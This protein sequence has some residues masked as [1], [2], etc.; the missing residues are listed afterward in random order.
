MS[1][2]LS[3]SNL[4]TSLL[5]DFLL[6]SVHLSHEDDARHLVPTRGVSHHHDPPSKHSESD[7]PFLSIVE[8]V[9][10]E[11]DAAAGE[12]LFGI[13]NVEALLGTMAAVLGFISL[14]SH[15]RL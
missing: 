6:T 15:A 9:V 13:G 11:A 3:R 1:R 2:S 10:D 14:I 5:I 4:A 12:D 8:T 7:Q